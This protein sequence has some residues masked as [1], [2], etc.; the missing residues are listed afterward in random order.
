[1]ELAIPSLYTMSWNTNLQIV[2]NK[3]YVM[4]MTEMIHDTRMIKLS[5]E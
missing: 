1:V 5:G 4:I 2:Q 3:D